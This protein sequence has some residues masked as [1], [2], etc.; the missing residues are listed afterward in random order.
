MHVTH[1]WY[2]Y[3]CKLPNANSIHRMVLSEWTKAQTLCTFEKNLCE[4]CT[5]CILM[6][7]HD[8]HTLFWNY[9][10]Y[11]VI[12]ITEKLAKYQVWNFNYSTMHTHAACCICCI[13]PI[14][15]ILSAICVDFQ[16]HLV[17][18]TRE[19]KLKIQAQTYIGRLD[20]NTPHV[21]AST[22]ISVNQLKQKSLF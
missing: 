14:S 2:C 7:Q 13:L 21:I 11:L 20:K 5:V 18:H 6:G 8:N 16:W 4:W 19:I 10:T 9:L 15:L 3:C 1:K 17:G 12:S 22:F